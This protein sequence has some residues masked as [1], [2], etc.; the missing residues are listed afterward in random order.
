MI[1]LRSGNYTIFNGVELEI[2]EDR[3][4]APIP[5]DELTC[6]ICYDAQLA[7]KFDDFF[8]ESNKKKCCKSIKLKE[9]TNAFFV[10]TF[11]LYQN[12]VVKIFE[13]KPNPKIAYIT[14]EDVT[15]I[16]NLSFMEVGY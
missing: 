3:F 4:D 15:S 9:L 14:T 2:Y 16:K 1:E 13:F 7:Y 8:Y 12:A 11:G 10:Q 6:S 5:K